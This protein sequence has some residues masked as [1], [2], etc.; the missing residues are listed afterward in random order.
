LS[1]DPNHVEILRSG[2][3]AWN[4][5]RE[6][7]PSTVPELA[8][9]A[10]KLSE[11]Q[12]G[13]T[14]GGPINLKS[15][16]LQNAFLRFATLLAADLEAADMSGADLMH[17]RFD[18]ANLS[19][20][21]LSNALLDHA[22]FAGANLAKV[23]L[24]GASLYYAKNL[25][26]AQLDKSI[27][28]DSTIL[29]PHLRGSVSWPM[30]RSQT[31]TMA[32]KPRKPTRAQHAADVAIPH[33]SSYNHRVWGLGVLLIGAALVATGFVWQHM[34]E[35][36]PPNT[37][38]AQIGSEPFIDPKLSLDSGHQ[39]LL[40][41]APEAV[42]GAAAERQPTA[43]AETP[44]MP[45]P[46]STGDQTESTPERRPASET[47]GA[48][49]PQETNAVDELQAS[50]GSKRLGGAFGLSEQAP[51][52]A[53]EGSE[54][55]SNEASKASTLDS[56]ESL[57]ATSRHG[58]VPDLPA[59]SIPGP[60]V[61]AAA[62]PA[63]ALAANTPD[64]S[65]MS[66]TVPDLPDEASIP[67]PQVSP[68]ADPAAEALAGHTPESSGASSLSDTPPPPVT[69]TAL[70]SSVEKPPEGPQVVESDKSN[71]KPDWAA[72]P[73]SPVRKPVIQTS[74]MESKPPAETLAGNTPA[75]SIASSLNEIPTHSVTTAALP[76]SVEQKNAQPV[77]PN[78]PESPPMPVRKPITQK[79]EVG[80]KPD[81]A[82]G[83]SQHV[84]KPI[85]QKSAMDSKPDRN[86]RAKGQN[87][88]N[89]QVQQGPGKSS[90]ADL[91]AG[92]F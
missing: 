71:P 92:G 16:R 44:P 21:N 64:S 18:H 68:A 24:C 51:G 31:G 45:S 86:R 54:P 84:R 77:L 46:G 59:A 13:P 7:N 79:S 78:G 6:K 62:P 60:Q 14:N 26:Q 50:D 90:I 88:V 48:T 5:W 25:T 42:M 82:K 53:E 34:R 19:A 28:S 72:T 1:P 75:P 66:A 36:V 27:G 70:P 43:D 35:V 3:P 74:E 56:S 17:A 73:P 69:T 12:M 33:T 91:L 2:P 81:R 30:A 20:A 47:D 32:L 83:L 49:V 41:T 63:E 67:T 10:L 58:T 57:V 23:N 29:P 52:T 55:K 89:T 87:F 85:V 4:A 37:S 15:A 80:P 61:P 22:D 11:R 8:G 65:S 38:G 9:I 76:S 39:G 40:P